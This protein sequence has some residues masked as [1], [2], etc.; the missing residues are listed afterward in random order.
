MIEIFSK[1]INSRAIEAYAAAFAICTQILIWV[2]KLWLADLHVPFVYTGDAL[3]VSAWIKGIVD[4]G[5]Y[6]QNGFIGVP[7]GNE[8]SGMGLS[9]LDPRDY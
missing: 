4:N 2:M 6:L 9:K 5:W 3:H 8:Q 1:R 7:F